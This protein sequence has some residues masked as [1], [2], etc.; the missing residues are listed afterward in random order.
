MVDVGAHHGGTLEIYARVGWKIYAFEPD[1]ENRKLLNIV[2]DRY[3][4]VIVDDRAVTDKDSEKKQFY[5]SSISSGI[6]GLSAFHTSHK[7]SFFI[8]TVTLRKY[9]RENNISTIN[10][11]KIDTEGYDLFV[12]KGHPWELVKPDIVLCEFEDIKTQPLGYSFGD[13]AKYLTRL[14]YNLLISEWYP[15]VE[16]GGNHHW[17]KFSK[18]PCELSDE[19]AW[20]NI[21]GV[22]NQ[23]SFDELCKLA[24]EYANKY[25]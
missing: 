18:F 15:I 11:L 9:Y 17:R 8:K 13:L 10:F 22:N 12:L 3:T 2:S 23:K 5:K 25:K 16:Y 7:P 1:P 21:I 20:G 6:S 19:K 4:N 14:G 24:N